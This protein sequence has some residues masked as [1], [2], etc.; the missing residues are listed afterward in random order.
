MNNLYKLINFCWQT[1]KMMFEDDS[2]F[3]RMYQI[4]NEAIK[5]TT[6]EKDSKFVKAVMLAIIE[7]IEDEWREKKSEGNK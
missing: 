2:D 6:S 4:A 1:S 7:Y 3:K 5:N